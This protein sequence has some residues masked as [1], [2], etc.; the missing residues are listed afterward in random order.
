MILVR[1]GI[2]IRPGWRAGVAVEENR[3]QG[4]TAVAGLNADLQTLFE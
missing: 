2:S 1:L 3:E 4:G